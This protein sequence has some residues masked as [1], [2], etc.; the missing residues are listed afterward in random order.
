MIEFFMKRSLL[1][2]F[3]VALFFLFFFMVK[4][5]REMKLQVRQ[6]GDSFIEG[7]RIINKK[8]GSSDWVLTAARADFADN[9]RTAHL[10]D[11]RVSVENR[12]LTLRADKGLYNMADK[13]LF[14]EG[15]ATAIAKGYAVTADRVKFDSRSEK[16]R[17]DG[18]VNVE[19]KKFNVRGKGMD[20]DNAKQTMRIY[21]D[22]KATFY[23]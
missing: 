7:L 19:S 11:I 17:S 21:G 14:A 3:S 12:G 18:N 22:V 6:A 8:N 23:R 1:V 10:T 16:I 4:D 15:K 13:T 20:I 9:G 2:A 5:E